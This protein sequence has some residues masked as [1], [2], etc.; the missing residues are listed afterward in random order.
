MAGENTVAT[1]NGLFKEIYAD[2][3]KHLIPE[4]VKLMK[5]IPFSPR[6]KEIGNQYHQPVVL[7]LEHGITYASDSDGAFALD[8]AVNGVIKDAV[9]VGSQMMLRSQ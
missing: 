7:G 9:V 5:K 2:K 4:G 6:K 3:L 8:A 1:L